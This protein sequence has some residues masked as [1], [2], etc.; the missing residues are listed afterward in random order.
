LASYSRDG[1]WIYF[2][3]NRSGRPEIWKMPAQGGDAT[4]LTVNGGQ[5]PLE[6]PDGK[7]VFY[8]LIP[9]GKGIGRVPVEGGEAVLVTGSTARDQAFAVGREGIYYASFPETPTRQLIRFL[10]FSTGENRPVVV[11]NQEMGIGLSLSPDERYLIF[12]Q[13]DHAGSDLMLVKDFVAPR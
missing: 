7:S 11:A 9:A 6:S 5:M 3:S 4:R 1:H 12:T 13:R 8:A 2:S 10:N